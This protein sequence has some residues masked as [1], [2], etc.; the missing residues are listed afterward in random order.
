[1]KQPNN[2]PHPRLTLSQTTESFFA[3]SEPQTNLEHRELNAAR[4]ETMR[5]RRNLDRSQL[6]GYRCLCDQRERLFRQP[7]GTFFIGEA[8][9]N[10][11][12]PLEAI[13]DREESN[14]QHLPCFPLVSTLPFEG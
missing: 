8:N 10:R 13:T 9:R 14:E 1:M 5:H 2:S 12:E 11:K 6:S 4:N 7:N 3:S